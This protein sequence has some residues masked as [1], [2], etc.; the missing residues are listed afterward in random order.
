MFVFA[1]LKRIPIKAEANFNSQIFIKT[2]IP[3]ALRLALFSHI[4]NDFKPL[5]SIFTYKFLLEKLVLI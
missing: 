5:N 2:A 1:P 4:I 3:T